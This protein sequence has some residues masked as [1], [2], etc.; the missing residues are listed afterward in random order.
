MNLE[1]EVISLELAK[2]LLAIGVKQNST[3]FWYEGYDSWL[4]HYIDYNH[5][6][7]DIKIFTENNSPCYSAF[8]AGELMELLPPFIDTGMNEPFNIFYLSIKK[9]PTKNIQYIARYICDSIP[10]EQIDNPFYEITHPHLKAYS[11]KLSDCLAMMF[12][13]IIGDKK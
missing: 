7:E 11:E 10:G 4:L 2:K 1:D 12:I 9:R 8:T 13:S 6:E 3:F 5:H